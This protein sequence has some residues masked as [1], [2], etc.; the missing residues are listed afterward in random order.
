[1]L[2][3]LAGA[4]ACGISL[5]HG[6]ANPS[7]GGDASATRLRPPVGVVSGRASL[8][9]GSGRRFITW[10]R[11]QGAAEL[12]L[13]TGLGLDVWALFILYFKRH[14]LV[15]VQSKENSIKRYNNSATLVFQWDNIPLYPYSL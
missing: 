12:R 8:L 9:R 13:D 1:M 15:L 14:M 6:D 3:L 10:G 2:P 11:G 4:E 7:Y 5:H